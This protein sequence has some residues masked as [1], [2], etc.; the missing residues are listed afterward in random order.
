MSLTAGTRL[1]HYEI[2]EGIGAGGTG[3]SAYDV[4]PD[5]R[6]FLMVQPAEA[7]RPATQIHIVLN[8]FEEL[9]TAVFSN[10]E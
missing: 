6:R 1:G 3:V 7:A 9:K 4:S 5:G 10:R 8:W 2:I